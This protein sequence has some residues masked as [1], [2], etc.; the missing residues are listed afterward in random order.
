MLIGRVLRSPHP[1][2]RIRSIGTSRA[3][4]LEG[5]KAV[6]ATSAAI[7]RKALSLIEVDDEGEIDI[8]FLP[9]R[10][11]TYEFYIENMRDDGMLGT[12]VVKWRG[13]PE[14]AP[15]SE[16]AEPTP[17]ATGPMASAPGIGR[18]GPHGLSDI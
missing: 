7:A 17:R 6:A 4:A 15:T 11:G 1:H 14:G 8:Y 9:I 13:V 12:F 10:P 5:V 16:P 3:E 2:A 18:C